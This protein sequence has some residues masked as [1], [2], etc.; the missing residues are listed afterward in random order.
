M[1]VVQRDSPFFDPASVHFSTKWW[2]DVDR[3]LGIL[4]NTVIEHM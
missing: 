2:L 3:E 1:M 4:G